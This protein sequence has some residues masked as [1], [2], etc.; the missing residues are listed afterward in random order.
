MAVLDLL[1]P[2]RAIL[3]PQAS[4]SF[5]LH[6]EAV[7]A[8]DWLAAIVQ[9]AV[10]LEAFLEDAMT[11]ARLSVPSRLEL[12]AAIAKLRG[13]SG[14]LHLRE[15]LAIAKQYGSLGMAWCIPMRTWV[16]DWRLRAILSNTN[17]ATF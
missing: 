1:A 13:A 16:L 17:W 11:H 15:I 8:R 14:L 4:R 12:G 9:G 7:A 5:D 2:Y 3:Q 10:F 6:R